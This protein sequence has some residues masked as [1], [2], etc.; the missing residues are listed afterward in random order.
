MCFMPQIFSIESVQMILTISLGEIKTKM[1]NLPITYKI[2]S[3]TQ[4]SSHRIHKNL[5]KTVNKIK[6]RQQI[7]SL[8]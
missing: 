1:S 2:P 5:G 8:D 3:I 4:N 6:G 7:C